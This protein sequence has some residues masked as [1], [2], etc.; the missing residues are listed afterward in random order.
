MSLC[1]HCC[2]FTC[3]PANRKFDVQK[4]VNDQ[5]Y[6]WHK[7]NVPGSIAFDCR[8]RV[9]DIYHPQFERRIPPFFAL[10]ACHKP[11]TMSEKEIK[12]EEGRR[13]VS[14]NCNYC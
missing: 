1:C 8:V 2:L 12:A 6:R 3:F 9:G 7:Q 4:W 5:P 13:A 14:C 11:T 10:E